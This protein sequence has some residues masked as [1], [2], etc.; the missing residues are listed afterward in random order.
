MDGGYEPELLLIVKG[1]GR[2][3]NPTDQVINLAL[4]LSR[5]VRGLS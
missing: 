3:V 5:I 1:V 4:N 2:G